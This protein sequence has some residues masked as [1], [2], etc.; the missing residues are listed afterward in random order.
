VKAVW[1]NERLHRAGQASVY[2]VDPQLTRIT[3]NG[4]WSRRLNRPG[5][6]RGYVCTCW[7]A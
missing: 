5:Q 1:V 6:C 4:L 2:A 3:A 7:S